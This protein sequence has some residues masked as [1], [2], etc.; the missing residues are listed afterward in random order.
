[1]ILFVSGLIATSVCAQPLHSQIVEF[2]SAEQLGSLVLAAGGCDTTIEE[3]IAYWESPNWEDSLIYDHQKYPE[4]KPR[5]RERTKITC[6]RVVD[7]AVTKHLVR[8]GEIQSVIW[9]GQDVNDV[10][11]PGEAIIWTREVRE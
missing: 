3:Y 7:V 1:M 10:I 2:S 9:K 5:Y 8:R 4:L 6:R 11:Y